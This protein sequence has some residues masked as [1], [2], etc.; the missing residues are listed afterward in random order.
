[1]DPRVLKGLEH[2]AKL[3]EERRITETVFV[4]LRDQFAIAALQGM[5]AAPCGKLKHETWAGCA[6]DAYS[7]ADAMLAARNV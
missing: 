1:M 6:E 2:E 4:N 7:L 3:L 5:L